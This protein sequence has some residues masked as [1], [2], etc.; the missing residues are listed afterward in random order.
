M[1]FVCALPTYSPWLNP[2]EA[3]FSQTKRR[4]LFARNLEDPARRRRALNTHFTQRAAAYALATTRR[5]FQERAPDTCPCLS[6]EGLA[7]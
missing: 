3:I 6:R 7:H 5:D 4:V 1:I 2:V